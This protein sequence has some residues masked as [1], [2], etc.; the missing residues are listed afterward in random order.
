MTHERTHKDFDKYKTRGPVHWREF[1][2][3]DPRKFNAYLAARYG[4]ILKF[5]GNVRGKRVLDMGCGDGVL[6]YLLAKEGADVIGTDTSDDGL[7]FA[8]E[9]V[10][11]RDP[12]KKL[13]CKFQYASVYD[14]PLPDESFDVVVSCEVIEH[15]SEPEKMLSEAQRLLKKDGM[16]ILTTPYRITEVPQDENH[17]REY[18][19]NELKSVV[20]TFFADTELQL[21]H[22]MLWRSLYTYG[23]RSLRGRAVGKWVINALTLLLSWNP[24]MIAYERPQKFDAFATICVVGKKR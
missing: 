10:E 20:G 19:P 13:M 16:I 6:S 22:H 4:W 21:T 12:L 24:F 8:R 1:F 5:A 18:F 14:V 23:F 2:S 7:R 15:L 3:R 11:V 9:Q 17:V